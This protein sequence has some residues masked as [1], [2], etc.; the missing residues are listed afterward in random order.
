MLTYL[1]QRVAQF[2]LVLIGVLTIV[3][4]LQHMSGDPT[5]LLVPMDAPDS[6]RV[7]L[8]HQLGLDRPLGDST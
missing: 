4:L 8:R 6:A 7:E 5:S 1:A 2:A 3:F